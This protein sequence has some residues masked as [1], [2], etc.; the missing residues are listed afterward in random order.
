MTIDRKHF[1]LG[2]SAY[3]ALVF[4][5]CMG[6]IHSSYANDTF[7]ENEPNIEMCSELGD[8]AGICKDH[9][10]ELTEIEGTIWEIAKF[11]ALK[12]HKHYLFKNINQKQNKYV[13]AAYDNARAHLDMLIKNNAVYD[14]VPYRPGKT[15]GNNYF[16][17]HLI[18]NDSE[19]ILK[20]N[21]ET[22]PYIVVLEPK[23]GKEDNLNYFYIGYYTSEG[24]QKWSASNP[25]ASVD[26][27]ESSFVSLEE[28]NGETKDLLKNYFSG[29]VLDEDVDLTGYLTHAFSL[30]NIRRNKFQIEVAFMVAELNSIKTRYGLAFKYKLKKDGTIRLI[31][32]PKFITQELGQ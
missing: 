18:K 21:D 3:T 1:K 25:K 14:R 31:T 8:E 20:K 15:Y 7:E 16:K 22:T 28:F 13:V 17:Y 11:D 9:E 12:H 2:V 24:V 29:N 4:F 6:W 10:A 27:E 23:P 32:K 5:I 30:Q 26:P 19:G